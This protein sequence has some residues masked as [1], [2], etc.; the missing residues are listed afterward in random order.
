MRHLDY[1]KALKSKG[2][3]VTEGNFK[4][5]D[6]HCAKNNWFCSF[7]E[8]KQTDVS[9]GVHMVADAFTGRF[10]RAV[11]ITADTDQVPTIEMIQR[12]FPKLELTWLAPPGRMQQAREIGDLITDRSELTSGA[13]GT[14]RLPTIVLDQDGKLVCNCP[15]PY[16]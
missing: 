6:K 4:R 7:N 13:I 5:G 2:V 14:C 11:L 1:I 16:K 8:E 15:Q 3:T 9:I 10:A 12:H